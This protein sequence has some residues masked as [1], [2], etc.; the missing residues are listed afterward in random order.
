LTREWFEW[1]DKRNPGQPFFGFLLYD[2]TNAR[3]FPP[4]YPVQFPAASESPGAESFADYQSS[5]HFVDDLIGAVLSDL[6]ERDLLENTVVLITSDHG[7]EFGESDEKLQRHG[8]GYTRH[9]LMTPMVV[10]WPG[11]TGGTA[12][13]HRTSHYD[14][15]P[16]IM[17]DLMGCSNP[18]SDYSVGRNLFDPKGWDWL[19]AGSYYNYA[20]IEPDQVTV[21]YPNGL[22]EVR[23]L[24]YRLLESPQFR[25]DVLEAVSE[26]N[27][28]F[29]AK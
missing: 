1:L 20:V 27:A 3:D 21:T 11:K 2:T 25:G 12:Y 7:E 10:S 29:F 19:L 26:Q 17:Q 14:I 4:D 9:Q 15:V 18:P 8:S 5:V 16:T 23:D 6:R 22:Y 24:D 28:R 13:D